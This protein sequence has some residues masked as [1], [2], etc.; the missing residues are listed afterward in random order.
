MSW[1][2]HLAWSVH[3]P[4]QRRSCGQE[5]LTTIHLRPASVVLA[6]GV[7]LM[8]EPVLQRGHVLTRALR[9]DL[10]TRHLQVLTSPD[11]SGRTCSRRHSAVPT[12]R[13][14]ETYRDTFS[15]L[16]QV[17]VDP[18]RTVASEMYFYSKAIEFLYL[19]PLTDDACRLGPRLL[20]CGAPVW[21]A[22]VQPV[23]Q[24]RTHDTHTKLSSFPRRT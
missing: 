3:I 5:K 24:P 19:P 4:R 22:H 16:A 21:C 17:H 1:R 10:G 18:V 20:R 7:D 6:V 12:D 2:V 23:V 15:D 9:Q 14:S 8:T 11:L 13:G